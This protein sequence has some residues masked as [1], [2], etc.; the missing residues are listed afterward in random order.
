MTWKIVFAL[1]SALLAVEADMMVGGFRDIDVNNEG[2]QNALNFAVVQHNRKS[3]DVYLRQVAQVV[4]AQVQVVAGL[5]YVLTV[6]LE[7]TSCRKDRA[8]EQCDAQRKSADAQPYQ[9]KFTV[10][11]R[12]W[13]NDIRV[14]D[15]KC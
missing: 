2:V 11:D 10:W 9:C 5:K 7:K 12:P 6:N 1:L 4:K 13:M 8:N 14:I 3:N 15:E